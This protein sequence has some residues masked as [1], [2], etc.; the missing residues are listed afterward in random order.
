MDHVRSSVVARPHSAG[1]SLATK[2]TA[3]N[4]PFGVS[5]R[6]TCWF[7]GL[8]LWPSLDGGGACVDCDR[9]ARFASVVTR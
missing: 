6:T 8:P 2:R 5:A 7:C 9:G 4:K 3:V 1:H